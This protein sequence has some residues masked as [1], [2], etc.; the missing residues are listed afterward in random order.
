MVSVVIG[1]VTNVVLDFILI[2]LCGLGIAGAAWGTA[3]AQCFTMVYVV[4]FLHSRAVPVR[5]CLCRVR[6]KKLISKKRLPFQADKFYNKEK[7]ACFQS[8][9][10]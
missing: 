1:A 4:C 9:F 6:K 5:L 7:K 3:A 2:F 10:T 8:N